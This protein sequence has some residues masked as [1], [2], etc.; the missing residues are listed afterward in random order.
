MD[1]CHRN[2]V[3]TGK[4][5]ATRQQAHRVLVFPIYH[6]S[7]QS[8]ATRA[9]IRRKRE[10]AFCTPQRVHRVLHTTPARPIANCPE[11]TLYRVSLDDMLI[12]IF[13]RRNALC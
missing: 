13:L 8:S 11:W 1:S 9:Q 7:L 12:V 2:R 6:A 4:I 3:Q 5:L 10:L